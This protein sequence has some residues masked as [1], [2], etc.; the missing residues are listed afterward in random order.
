MTLRVFVPSWFLILFLLLPFNLFAQTIDT[1]YRSTYYEQKV[2]LFRMLPD[3]K[4][5]IIFLGNSI[6]DIGEWTEIWQNLKVKNRGISGDNTFGEL[7]RLDEVLSSKPEKIFLMIGINDIAKETADSIII[8]NHRKICQ[9]IKAASPKTKLY[10][11]S[12]LPTNADFTE[13]K[14]HQNKDEHIRKVNTAL[15]KTCN[16]Y[17]LTY[18]DLY[19]RFVDATG[20]L[21]KRYTNDGL[22]INGYGY[23]LWKQILAEKGY[24]K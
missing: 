19:S 18:I 11:Q 24:M 20:K 1:T 12:I 23:M 16:E 6:T 17:G 5:E 7:A 21:D 9:R 22:H 8:T 10:V 2:T 14:R 3:T 13:F 4:G 15:Q